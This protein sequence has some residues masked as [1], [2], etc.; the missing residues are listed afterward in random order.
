MDELA[1][2]TDTELREIA[3]LVLAAV[4]VTPRSVS[5]KG[6]MKIPCTISDYHSDQ[7]K[8]PTG[9][10]N[11]RKMV[12]N[13]LGCQAGGTVLWYIA[14]NLGWSDSKQ[15]EN[16]LRKEAGL[17]DLLSS[18]K[19]FMLV[20]NMYEGT[21]PPPPIPKYAPRTLLKWIKPEHPYFAERDISKSNALK[22]MLGYDE[23][24]NRVVIPHFFEGELVG[25]QTRTLDGSGEKYKNSTDFPRESTI[26]NYKPSV[27]AVVMES[28][29][30]VMR[31]AGGPYHLEATFG[32]N[33]TDDQIRLLERHPKVILWMDNDPNGAGWKSSRSMIKRLFRTTNV[34]IVDSPYWGDPGEL[35]SSVVYE[36]ISNAY[37]A[38]LWTGPGRL[39]NYGNP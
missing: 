17:K 35:P 1:L 7:D 33:V 26:F 21:P 28:T 14:E 4:G 30:S 24:E 6:E 36:L 20:D 18:E 29:F 38:A 32:T 16:W 23:E 12:F 9:A 19:L 3:D 15:S 2:L 34:W 31:H 39:V 37:P 5:R 25:W 22:F 11:Y 13:C 27:E 10:L 8:H